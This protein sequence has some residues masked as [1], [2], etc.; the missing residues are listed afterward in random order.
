MAL[1][2]AEQGT[3]VE[4][5][6]DFASGGDA[7]EVPDF[8]SGGEEAASFAKEVMAPV[9]ELKPNLLLEPWRYVPAAEVA[10]GGPLEVGR[11]DQEQVRKIHEY[12]DGLKELAGPNQPEKAAAIEAAR[13][14]ALKQ[15]G[16]GVVDFLSKGRLPRVGQASTTV[17]KV[18]AG[19]VNAASGAAEFFVSPEGMAVLGSGNLPEE[20]RRLVSAGFAAQM[21]TATPAVVKELAQAWK[22]GD[23]QKATELALQAGLNVA[24]TKFAAEHAAGP[25]TKA[26]QFADVLAKEPV[27]E[28]TKLDRADPEG[29]VAIQDLSTPDFAG[30]GEEVV[31]SGLDRGAEGDSVAA[32]ETNTGRA[33][34]EGKASEMP[35]EPAVAVTPGA[36]PETVRPAGPLEESSTEPTP[37]RRP[38]NYWSNDPERPFDIIDAIES[39]VGKIRGKASARPGSEGYYGEAYDRLR[40]LGPFRR[41]LSNESGMAPDEVT[42]AL[43]RGGFLP[44]HASVDDMWS[45]VEGAIHSRREWRARNVREATALQ[46]EEAQQLDFQKQALKPGRGK[47]AVAVSDLLQGDELTIAGAKFKVKELVFDPESTELSHVVL[48]DGRRFGVKT[49]DA[50]QVIHADKGSVKETP[51]DV[52]FVPKELASQT[53]AGT[54]RQEPRPTELAHRGPRGRG[55]APTPAPLPPVRPL[56]SP[57]PAPGARAGTRVVPRMGALWSHLGNLRRSV[58]SVVSPANLD[59]QARIFSLILRENNARAALDL[60][61]SDEALKEFRGVFDRTPVPKDWKYDPAR[62]LPYNYAVMD[63]LER[64]RNALPRELQDFAARFDKEFAWRIAEV[65]RLAP[66]AMQ[67]LIQNYFPHIWEK[68][69]LPAVRAL[70]AEVS[71][72][73]PLHGAKG[74]LKQRSISFIHEG[75]MR[76]LK[77][78]SDNPVDVVLAKMHQ[79]DKFIMAERS[80]QEAEASGMR[81]YLPL[82]RKLPD[83]WVMVKDPAFTV[84]LPPVLTVKEAF[85]AGVRKGLLDFIQKMG[86]RHERVASLGADKWGVFYQGSGGQLKSRFGGPDFVITHEVG[87]G[88]DER[89][90]LWNYMAVNPTLR[91][92]L[93]DLAMLRAGKGTV[94]AG[95]KKY[96]QKPE[97]QM[98]NMVHAYVHA[99]ELMERVAPHVKAAFADFIR[100]HPELE[101]LNEIKPT[102]EL[103]T[104]QSELPLAG[105]VL[106]GHYIMPAGPAAVLTNYLSP[107]LQRFLPYRTLRAAS[108]ILNSAQLGLS[109]FHVGFT[110][111]DAAISSVAVGLQQ[112]LRGD[113]G[114]GLV[115][116]GTAGAAPLTNYFTGKAVQE[117]MVRPGTK[118]VRV[119]DFPSVGIPGVKVPFP[120]SMET[121]LSQVAQLAVRGGLRAT[122]DPFWQ[123]Q[124]TRNLVRAFHEGGVKGYAGTVLRAPFAAVEQAMRPIAEY[125]VPRQKLGVFAQLAHAEM[126]RLGPGASLNQVRDAMAKAADTTEDRMGQMTY[127]NLFYN[128]AV[129]DVALLAF[130]AYGWQLGKYRASFGAVGDW[131]KFAYGAAE[132]GLAHVTGNASKTPALEMTNRMLYPVALVAT[133]AALGGALNYLWTGEKPK[134]LRDY[135]FPRNGELDVH[136]RPQRVALPTYMKDLASDWKDFPEVKK[137]GASFYHKLNPM[138]AMTVD[139]LRNRDFYDTEVYHPDDPVGQKAK[140]LVM[141]AAKN[142]TPFSVTGYQ[143]MAE[144]NSPELQ[145]LLPFIGIVPAK[146]SVAQTPAEARAADI[147][148]GMMP[149]GTR[150]K[151]EF[152]KSKF[153]AEL[154]RELKQ[155]PLEGKNALVAG[156][157][158]GK[159]NADDVTKLVDRAQLTPLQYQVHKMP[160][161]QGM[162]V[163]DL[164]NDQ[165]RESLRAILALKLADVKDME[166]ALR[167]KYLRQVMK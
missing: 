50:E 114:K 109:G 13:T 36:I 101:D 6:P 137:M 88:L 117:R 83:G 99:P 46:A 124:I 131:M 75:L 102:L 51:R 62:P 16:V 10:K 4:D 38:K 158:A 25:G 32:G 141:F 150:T 42:D 20:L 66:T 28:A 105:P 70:M 58:Q 108:N 52:E 147:M 23:T 33:S 55:P 72:R 94:P 17:G 164:A 7:Q 96:L 27:T 31:T 65:R 87:H 153:K 1:D 41:V 126:D 34:D 132:K 118:G 35:A 119:L 57:G 110:S 11:M 135:L 127:D 64:D 121:K 54:A 113:V 144:A 19:A 165:E 37:P 152:E 81:K 85:D 26:Q 56:P 107:G 125:L 91:A 61:R 43:R 21:A 15:E 138:V 47:E 22:A 93:L 163:W 139:M 60:V 24:F 111:L 48:E 149:A 76:G 77:P 53:A 115:R 40:Q 116:L 104:A 82:G 69:D 106:A 92:E 130:R 154:V 155:N 45:A 49:V 146:T 151:E 136:G 29:Q 157:N 97:E 159:V 8:S 133:T 167:T 14:E 5:V 160:A 129:K 134:E 90:G 63:A 98:A 39:E 78:I 59:A 156:L 103:A 80:L 18:A 68:A 100:A 84:H 44:E 143:K 9:P 74:F 79:M 2:F 95:F 128:R 12:Y 148:Q 73:A 120:A 30:G 140:D 86:F 142:A 161:E 162:K 67:H 145:R 71:A 166:P 112:V 89:Y 123:T 122:V 3:P